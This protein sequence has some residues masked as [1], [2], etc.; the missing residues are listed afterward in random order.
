[1]RRLWKQNSTTKRWNSYLNFPT[2]P[3]PSHFR[4]ETFFPLWMLC[5]GRQG[6]HAVSKCFDFNPHLK[7]GEKNNGGS[8]GRARVIFDFNG[9]K[10][11]SSVYKNLNIQSRRSSFIRFC[12]G[13][14]IY[15]GHGTN[16]E[17]TL[18]KHDCIVSYDTIQSCLIHSVIPTT[19][20]SN[21]LKNKITFYL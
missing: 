2:P 9:F 15:H 21:K 19:N 16:I 13:M 8:N 14:I 11:I 5:W 1:M 7:S 18:N 12:F 20:L 3:S 4:N 10:R 6:Y 17:Q